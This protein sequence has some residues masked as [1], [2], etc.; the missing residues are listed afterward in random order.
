MD[1][2]ICK[3][4][5]Y[6]FKK[7]HYWQITL[8]YYCDIMCAMLKAV[9]GTLQCTGRFGSACLCKATNSSAG[10]RLRS[11]PLPQLGWSCGSFDSSLCSEHSALR[12]ATSLSRCFSANLWHQVLNTNSFFFP[13][14]CRSGRELAQTCTDSLACKGPKQTC[15]YYIVLTKSLFVTCTPFPL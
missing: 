13:G 7:C 12:L 15:L 1:Y 9:W 10:D 5:T 14:P 2:M 11:C 4:I 3:F 8:T 6:Y